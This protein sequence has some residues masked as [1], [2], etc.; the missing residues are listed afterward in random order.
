MKTYTEGKW[1]SVAKA[2]RDSRDNVF[3]YT[4]VLCNDTIRVARSSGVGKELALGNA[5]LI[6][7]A[8]DLLEA[9]SEIIPSIKCLK[10]SG[11]YEKWLSRAEA[12]IAKAEA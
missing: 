7:A 1:E 8:P 12:A 4:D 5:R 9:L 3:S 11:I 2:V 6:A 10:Q